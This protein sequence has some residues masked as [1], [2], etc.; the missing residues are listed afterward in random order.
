MTNIPTSNSQDSFPG[1]VLCE[2]G[3]LQ[4]N[5]GRETKTLTVANLGDRPIQIGSH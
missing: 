5:A 2:S 3:S 4:L 1:E